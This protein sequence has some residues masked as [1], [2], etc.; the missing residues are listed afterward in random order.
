M[1]QTEPNTAR[2]TRG[3]N[4]RQLVAV[5][6]VAL[7]F[8]GQSAAAYDKR[9]IY[10]L[11]QLRQCRLDLEEELPA[12]G[13]PAVGVA[14]TPHE[15]FLLFPYVV[16]IASDEDL[17]EMLADRSPVVRIMGAK[18]AVMRNVSVLGGA[19]EEMTKDQAKVY[20]VSGCV[21]T[22]RTAGEIVTELKIHPTFLEEMD[23]NPK[24]S[25][26]TPPLATPR[27]DR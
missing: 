1:K 12:V 3:R 21:V 9:L 24:P 13:G 14:A 17:K 19:V 5:F 22:K 4:M 10:V 6:C 8:C 20:V 27:A 15:F 7:F 25:E 16:R 23:E 18:C 11:E 26:T 2:P